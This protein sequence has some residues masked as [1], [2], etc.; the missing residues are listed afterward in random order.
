MWIFDKLLE[1]AVGALIVVA[2]VVGFAEVVSRY[3]LG[4][5]IGWSYEFLQIV[6]VYITFVGGF[7]ATRT[8]S[9]LRVTVIVEALP[10]NIRF[11]CFL[12][13]KIG[14][15][16]TTIVMTIWGWEYAFRFSGSS[17]DILRVPVV[18]LYIV[19]PICGFAMTLQV[20]A[21]LVMG[22]WKFFTEGEAEKFDFTLPGFGEEMDAEKGLQT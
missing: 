19:V 1:V 17:T 12:V 8:Q 4:G 11:I 22:I 15:A 10:R 20:I 3:A 21:D 18:Y 6:L 5:S 13:A 2:T 14:V 16:I 9:H 7:L